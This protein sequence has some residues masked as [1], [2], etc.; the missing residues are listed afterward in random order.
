MKFTEPSPIVNPSADQSYE[1]LKSTPVIFSYFALAGFVNVNVDVSK[2]LAP[3]HPICTELFNESVEAIVLFV[4]FT[5][6]DFLPSV[7]QFIL[8]AVS[9]THLTLPTTPYV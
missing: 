1:I 5:D 3:V 6:N 8:N 7:V 2:Q 4:P 9:Y